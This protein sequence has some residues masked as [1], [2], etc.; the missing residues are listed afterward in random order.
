MYSPLREERL[1]SFVKS[2]IV[3]DVS[4]P[5]KIFITKTG[6]FLPDRFLHAEK[7]KKKQKINFFMFYNLYIN[8]RQHLE[9]TCQKL[10]I[11]PPR[12]KFYVPVYT[13]V[14]NIAI[15]V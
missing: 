9:S 11:E 5:Y 4:F 8:F 14:H 10:F 7:P 15:I 1:A 13:A 12:S 3:M 6:I 2:E